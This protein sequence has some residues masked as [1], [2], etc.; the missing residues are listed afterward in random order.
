M[1]SQDNEYLVG[2]P[3]SC[4]AY[5]QGIIENTKNKTKSALKLARCQKGKSLEDDTNLATSMFFGVEKS[6]YESLPNGK[7]WMHNFSQ[8]ILQQLEKDYGKDA[9]K[10]FVVHWDEP[11]AAPHIQAIIAPV[12]TVTTTN[13]YGTKERQA[14][15]HAALFIDKVNQMKLWRATGQ[16]DEK[17]KLGQWQT[18]YAKAVSYLGVDRGARNAWHKKHQPSKPQPPTEAPERM[19]D[20]PAKR[21]KSNYT[22]KDLE[23]AEALPSNV[24]GYVSNE[25]IA[26]AIRDAA[27]RGYNQ[28]INDCSAPF[29]TAKKYGNQARHLEIQNRVLEKRY[30][31]LKTEHERQSKMMKRYYSKQTQAKVRE[32]DIPTV[33]EALG[34]INRKSYKSAP[35]NFVKHDYFSQD[36]AIRIDYSKT[37]KGLWSDFRNNKTG[38]GAID[39][40]KH[41]NNCNFQEAMQW[42][43]DRFGI[44]AV[45]DTEIKR[46][47]MQK[48]DEIK[49]IDALPRKKFVKPEMA[50]DAESVELC[51][52]Y[53]AKRGIDE[54]TAN[55]LISRREIYPTKCGNYTNIVFCNGTNAA[56]VRGI[57]TGYKGLSQSSNRQGPAFSLS[58]KEKPKAIMVFESSLDLL[59]WQQTHPEIQDRLLCSVSG[60]GTE[61]EAKWI[62]SKCAEMDI[63]EVFIAYDNDDPGKEATKKL[64]AILG[65]NELSAH[66]V[67]PPEDVKDWNDLTIN[68]KLKDFPIRPKETMK[69]FLARFQESEKKKKNSGPSYNPNFTP[70]LRPR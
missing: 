40:I 65:E 31:D 26:Q 37:E 55:L 11:G 12:C 61:C 19:P 2:S 35:D 62:L 60:V 24:L 69:E 36:G 66:E 22:A 51:K 30:A 53:L 64:E 52:I 59:A 4:L 28:A 63:R 1:K 17:S 9:I 47:E 68:K 57:G 27:T 13:R 50:K 20:L 70:T 41:V 7:E 43:V 58:G 45:T 48:R 29:E 54:K 33:C 23:K 67:T 16:T 25:T 49:K 32:I 8:S 6:W 18:R 46:V 10:S 56:E 38:F 5:F 44:D 42:A 15:S 39:L 34:L 21:E 3:E 14:I